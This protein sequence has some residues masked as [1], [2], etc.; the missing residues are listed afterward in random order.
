MAICTS[1][2]SA[3]RSAVSI[4]AG[5]APQSS[6]TFSPAAPASTCSRSASG[7]LPFPLPRSP[8]LTG[9]SSTASSIRWMFQGPGVQVVPLDPSVG[10]VPPPKKLVMPLDRPS[11]ACWG[12]MK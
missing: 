11:W 6:C 9:R 7:R 1:Y 8:T 5:V 12:A 2:S 3:T 4:E 10:P